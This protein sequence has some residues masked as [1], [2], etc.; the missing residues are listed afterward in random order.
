MWKADLFSL[1]QIT[2]LNLLLIQYY[3]LSQFNIF[4]TLASVCKCA[5]KGKT[6]RLYQ[7]KERG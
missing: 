4:K 2:I 6:Y 7:I 5:S 1:F 3:P